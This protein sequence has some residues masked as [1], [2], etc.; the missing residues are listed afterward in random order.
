M[1]FCDKA[2]DVISQFWYEEL[3]FRE[4][5]E[6]SQGHTSSEWE[7]SDE[8]LKSGSR[9]NLP[10]QAASHIKRAVTYSNNLFITLLTQAF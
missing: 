6:L 2:Y 7:S 5:K 10:Q 9:V 8:N 3:R 1:G 4:V